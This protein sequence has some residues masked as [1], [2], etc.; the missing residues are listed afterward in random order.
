MRSVRVETA[1]HDQRNYAPETFMFGACSCNSKE[2]KLMLARALVAAF[3]TSSERG[4]LLRAVRSVETTPRLT[5]S[6]TACL[7]SYK[8]TA[9]VHFCHHPHKT[10]NQTH[11]QKWPPSSS[12]SAV[13]SKVHTHRL[14][15]HPLSIHAQPTN[16]PRSPVSV[17]LINAIAVLS[18]DRFLARSTFTSTPAKSP[19]P[20][21]PATLS[22]PAKQHS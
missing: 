9:P 16:H 12:P 8:T 17:L 19:E 4:T 2:A 20:A 3:P 7:H 22:R 5:T 15:N 14:R 6:R 11:P 1:M 10:A 21:K 18:E 13:S